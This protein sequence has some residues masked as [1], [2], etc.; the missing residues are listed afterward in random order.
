[1]AAVAFAL[2]LFASYPSLL[3]AVGA[4]RPTSANDCSM[5]VSPLVSTVTGFEI[6]PF[7]LMTICLRVDVPFS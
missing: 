5:L 2:F 4:L 7:I 1:M 3:E 6:A